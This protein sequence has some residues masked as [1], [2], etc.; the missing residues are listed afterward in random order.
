MGALVQEGL[1]VRHEKTK[2]YFFSYEFYL[3]CSQSYLPLLKEEWHN[4]LVR[5]AEESEDTAFLLVP[6]GYDALCIDRVE[7]TYPIRTLTFNIGDRRPLGIGAGGLALLSAYGVEDAERI[8]TANESRYRR[9]NQ[10]TSRD[11]RNFVEE[12][13]RNGHAQSF[14]NV[15]PGASSVALA[16]SGSRGE[17][18]AAVAI[19]AVNNRMKQAR[20]RMLIELLK[21]ELKEK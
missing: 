20:R 1:L 10:R 11:V 14:G 6:M 12:T 5:V 19:A 7:G 4:T 18:V 3:M 16:I 13:R 17:P 2:K 8:I 9:H 21:R 15:T